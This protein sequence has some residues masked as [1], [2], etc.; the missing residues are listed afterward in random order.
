MADE[1]VPQGATTT[2]TPVVFRFR[3]AYN[4]TADKR[5]AIEADD[6]CSLAV[7]MS[8]AVNTVLAAFPRIQELM[9]EIEELPIAHE[10]ISKLDTYAHAAGH[11]LAL[12]NAATAPPEQLEAVYELAL[13]QK[14]ALK[15][16]ATNLALRGLL[17]KDAVAGLRNEVGYRNVGY[18]L[19]SLIAI[20]RAAQTRIA[21]R[22]AILP[23]ELDSAE[24]VANE[25]LELAAQREAR[26]VVDPHVAEN[27][28]RALTLMVRTYDQ[29][30][31]AVT[32]IRWDR[33]DMEKYTPA[34]YGSK[35]VRRREDGTEL[36]P[37]LSTTPGTPTAP[38]GG[39]TPATPTV[40]GGQG[41]NPFGQ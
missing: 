4:T 3:D 25:L 12:Y 29:A 11:A 5:A 24:L 9:A 21:G 26:S 23:E 10:E 22:S 18:D 17:N 28:H 14:N 40:P 37:N 35:G 39:A 38:T 2:G 16:D 6:L 30:R 19:M 7:D 20:L 31:R 8:L 36:G 13:A 32:F 33:G 34:L 27:R 15:S 1:Q 41:G